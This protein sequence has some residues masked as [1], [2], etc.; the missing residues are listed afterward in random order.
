M[1]LIKIIPPNF[2]HILYFKD[3]KQVYYAI[4]K[5]FH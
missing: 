5:D 1:I 3:R 4:Q 2:Y